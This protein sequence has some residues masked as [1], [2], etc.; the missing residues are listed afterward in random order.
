MFMGEKFGR[1]SIWETHLTEELFSTDVEL[2]AI[3]GEKTLPLG[4]I[5]NWKPGDTI[6]FKSKPDDMV[7][8]RCGTFPMFK[9]ITGQ[10]QGQIAARI[11]KYIRPD[12]AKNNK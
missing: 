2:Q 6:L 3:L 1:D 8:M 10:K 12:K 11:E 9:A 7:E 4:Q 5:L